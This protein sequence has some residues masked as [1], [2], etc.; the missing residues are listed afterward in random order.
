MP[1]PI[2]N[3]REVTPDDLMRLFHRTEL[4]WARQVA[5]DEAALDCGVALT[6]P[7][8]PLVHQANQILDAFIPEG[9]SLADV[10]AMTDDHFRAAGT[11]CWKWT[12]NPSMPV[13]RTRPLEEHLLAHGFRRE[14][15]DLMY[16]KGRP[17]GVI[18]EVAGVKIIPARASF[19]HARQINEEAVAQWNT[20]GLADAMMMH[21]DDPHTDALLALKDGR[22]AALLEVLTVGELGC[23]EGLTVAEPF[24]GQGI[25]R[26]MMSRALE[27]CARSLHKHVFLT[28]NPTNAVAVGLYRKFGFEKIADFAFFRA[29]T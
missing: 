7:S 28:V 19:K 18:E 13:E 3:N 29:T 24:R 1:L 9:M 23:I 26:T 15:Y 6:N 20:P 10:V 17:A 14:T 2:L 11:R 4:H 16:L 21:L 27:V 22:A 12:I 5:Q 8:L 25:G